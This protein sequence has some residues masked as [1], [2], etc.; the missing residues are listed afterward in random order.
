[1]SDQR[2]CLILLTAIVGAVGLLTG[3]GGGSAPP[4][5]PAITV[6]V[7]PSSAMVDQGAT[8]TFTASV[9]GTTNTAVTWSVQE[10]PAGGTITSA[11]IYTAPSTAGTFHIMA[12]SQTDSAKSATAAVTVPSVSVAISPPAAMVDQA[13]TTSFSATVSGTIINTS[14]TWSVQEGSAGGT[15]SSAG[16]YTAPQAA[17]TFHLVATSQADPTKSSVSTI[18]VPAVSVAVS[19]MSDTLGPNGLRTFVATVSGTVVSTS[20]TWSVQEGAAGGSITSGGVYTAPTTTGTFHV[21]TAS[22]ANPSAS[23]AAIVTVVPSG[24]TPTADMGTSRTEHTATLLPDGKVLIAGGSDGSSTLQSAEIFD[25]ATNTFSATGNMVFARTNHTATLLANGKVLLCGGSGSSSLALATA[26]LYD[27]ATGTFAATGA[28]AVAR[29]RR[30]A[31]LLADNRVLIVGGENSAVVSSVEI[32]DPAPGAF[33]STGSLAFARF[34][35]AAALLASGK[36]L[37]AGGDLEP[38]A[39]LASA[40]LYDTALGTFSGTGSMTSSRDRFTLTLLPNGKVLAAGGFNVV[41]D[42][43]TGCGPI[44]LANVDL[45]DPSAGAFTAANNMVRPHGGHTATLLLSRK[46][47][48]VGGD[49]FAVEL[50]DPASGMFSLT[51]SLE[52][53]RTGHTATLLNDGRVLVTGGVANGTALGTAEVYR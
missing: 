41:G 27:P 21:V 8:R 25:P 43:T 30:T 32:Y 16:L 31:T 44:S 17:G 33:T 45:Y 42:C 46:V 52:G 40:E 9:T 2:S 4:P 36:V 10:G 1:M 37:V 35:H 29:S 15:V 13:A 26:E 50:F 6:S 47:L 51:G 49:T 22:V 24:F 20:V 38:S 34:N 28:M 48:I 11:G 14:V 19:P 5:P 23:G 12:T 3:C 7:S 53:A 18:T 39:V